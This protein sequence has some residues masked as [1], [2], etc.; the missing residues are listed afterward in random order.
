MSARERLLDWATAGR[1][2]DRAAEY[3]EI[4][5]AT[6]EPSVQKRYITIAAHYCALALAEKRS[7]AQRNVDGCLAAESSSQGHAAA[8]P[9][10]SQQLTEAR[11]PDASRQ[12][13]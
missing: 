1:Y 7:A 11:D 4:A 2:R 8:A 10:R 12:G 13:A 9:A 3:L 5:R 6:T